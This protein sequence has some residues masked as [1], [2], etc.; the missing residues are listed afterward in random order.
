MEVKLEYVLAVYNV[1]ESGHPVRSRRSQMRK[2]CFKKMKKSASLFSIQMR[3]KNGSSLQK[4]A[5]VVSLA[6]QTMPNRPL[7]LAPCR[8]N[9]QCGLLA[10][11]GIKMKSWGFR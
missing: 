3:S 8:S 10:I 11:V 7:P 5:G 2:N 6:C 4:I 1:S 9:Y